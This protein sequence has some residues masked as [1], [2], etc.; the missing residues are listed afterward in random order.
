MKLLSSLSSRRYLGH[1]I[2]ERTCIQ[3]LFLLDQKCYFERGSV[4]EY[5]Q[6]TQSKHPDNI[7]ATMRP[8]TERIG[9]DFVKSRIKGGFTDYDI[10]QF[11]RTDQK[12]EEE[13]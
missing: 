8:Q 12:P 3:S 13:K 4:T 2:F 5:Q 10:S 9:Y 11:K 7:W 6:V 1:E